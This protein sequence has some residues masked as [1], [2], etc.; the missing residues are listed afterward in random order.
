MIQTTLKYFSTIIIAMLVASALILLV[1]K[2]AKAHSISPA[3]VEEVV[4]FGSESTGVIQFTNTEDTEVTLEISSSSY[5]AKTNTYLTEKSYISS[6]TD[7]ITV[8]PNE[9]IEI[10]YTIEIPLD[11]ELKTHFFMLILEQQNIVLQEG[12]RLGLKQALGIVF[13]LHVTDE[14]GMQAGM[15]EKHFLENAE[16]KTQVINKG[17]PFINRTEVQYTL[18]NNSKYAFKFNGETRLVNSDQ[19]YEPIVF[20]INTSYDRI[21]PGETYTEEFKHK[22]W[23]RNNILARYS[24]ISRASSQFGTEYLESSDVFHLRY[25]AMIFG[26]VIGTI[27]VGTKLL[28]SRKKKSKKQ[29]KG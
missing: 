29:Q 23:S 7:K 9:Q 21:Y 5:D 3:I 26:A 8:E 20:R 25:E 17:Y 16:T 22:L 19:S 24:A 10:P 18:K 12:S 1:P 2:I 4:E 28:V 15:L 27:I 14:E 6:E 13:V 11:S